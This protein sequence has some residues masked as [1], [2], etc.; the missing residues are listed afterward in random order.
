MVQVYWEIPVKSVGTDSEGRCLIVLAY[1]YFVKPRGE[2]Y[3]GLVDS[4]ASFD[5]FS[6]SLLGYP[7]TF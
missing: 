1:G 7:L 5:G 6:S 4:F 3:I 2:P